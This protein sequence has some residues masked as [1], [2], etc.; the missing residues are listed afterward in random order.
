MLHYCKIASI[1]DCDYVNHPARKGAPMDDK[2]ESVE[3]MEVGGKIDRGKH[4]A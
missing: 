4:Y 2:G 1:Y 3:E